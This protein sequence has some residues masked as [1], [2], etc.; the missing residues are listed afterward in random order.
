M[1]EEVQPRSV[2]CPFESNGITLL[3]Q[4]QRLTRNARDFTAFAEQHDIAVLA[5]LFPPDEP[6]SEIYRSFPAAYIPPTPS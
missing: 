2:H 5:P 3:S 1:G 4:E 6:P